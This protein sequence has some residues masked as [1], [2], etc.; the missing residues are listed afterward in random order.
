MGTKKPARGGS[1]G[2]YIF[3]LRSQNEFW[4]LLIL[5][6]AAKTDFNGVLRLDRDPARVIDAVEQQR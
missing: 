1:V 5:L 3:T 6:S 4:P 2:T